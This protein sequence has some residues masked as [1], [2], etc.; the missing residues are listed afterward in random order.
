[1]KRFGSRLSVWLLGA[2]GALSRSSVLGGQPP[3]TLAA[4][5]VRL[6]WL[7]A[8]FCLF[9]SVPV[10][11]IY[12]HIH[13]LVHVRHRVNTPILRI[14]PPNSEHCRTSAKPCTSGV[15]NDCHLS[16]SFH[17]LTDGLW[18]LTA[19][20]YNEQRLL[21]YRT[22]EHEGGGARVCVCV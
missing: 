17:L 11:I 22:A 10:S 20:L 9:S 13:C 16:P 19:L 14:L 21:A 6:S 7:H 15:E 8:S 5:H 18:I 2:R 12:W 1:M 3:H 4:S